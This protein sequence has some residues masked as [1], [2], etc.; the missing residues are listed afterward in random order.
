MT[1]DRKEDGNILGTN[2]GLMRIHYSRSNRKVDE[3]EKEVDLLLWGCDITYYR[4][5]VLEENN[6]DVSFCLPRL[7]TNPFNKQLN[8][9]ITS[10]GSKKELQTILHYMCIFNQLF[11]L[12]VS[13]LVRTS[14]CSNCIYA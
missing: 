5:L 6:K 3:T 9:L 2:P 7:L 8:S 1:N 10:D 12:W 4:F 11:P 13:F 14:Y